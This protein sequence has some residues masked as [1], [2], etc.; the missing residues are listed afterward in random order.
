LSSDA[1]TP[2]FGY[3]IHA[4]QPAQPIA[5]VD[6]P[7]Q[8]GAFRWLHFDQAASG[9]P[10]WCARHMPP[11][12][13]ASLLAKK[14]R[15]RAD[16]LDDGLMLTLRG[17][18]L[19][20]GAE[21]EDMV[22][23]RL[24][25]TDELIVTVRNRRIFAVED[26]RTEIDSGTIPA[27]P[28]AFVAR[29]VED[30]IDRIETISLQLEERTDDLEDQVYEGGADTLPDL[31]PERRAAIKLLRHIRPQTDALQLLPALDTDLITATLRPRL[32]ET[33]NKA[34]RSVEELQ[35][36]RERLN[37]LSEHL[38]LMQTAR[39]GRNGYILSVV[40]AI[41]LPLGF[42]TGLFG[43]NVGGLPW[44]DWQWGFVSLCGAMAVL[45]ILTYAIFRWLRWF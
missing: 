8:G 23:L 33:A 3:D 32:R 20:E 45:G 30:L 26:M 2:I 21:V 40:A 24:W 19:N 11:L 18:N 16:L 36:V 39:L 22:S 31:A 5:T 9:L 44:V 38:D 29:L 35:E 28:A 25:V 41:F 6:T 34:T 15:P 27:S 12:A 17:I 4:G 13:A 14:V 42:L 37:A 1:P 7:F 43:V 10:A